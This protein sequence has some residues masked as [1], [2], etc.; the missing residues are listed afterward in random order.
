MIPQVSMSWATKPSTC[1]HC[2]NPIDTASPMVTA[3]FRDPKT[4]WNT[5]HYYHPQCWVQNGLEYLKANPYTERKTRDELTPEQKEVRN[6]IL[7]KYASL[8]QRQRKLSRSNPKHAILNMNIE[9]QIA[10]LMQ[11]ILPYGGVP[12]KWAD[13]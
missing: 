10:Q 9:A 8:R 7:R 5:R 13:E 3:F 1:K 12:R 6:Q 2:D 11:D 4:K